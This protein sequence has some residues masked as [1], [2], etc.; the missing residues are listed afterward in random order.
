MSTSYVRDLVTLFIGDLVVF[1]GSLWLALLARHFVAPNSVQYFEHLVPFSI[2]FA[3]WLIVFVIMGLYDR[4]VALF[5]HRLPSTIF[6]AQVVNLLLAI[7]FFFIAPIA[8]QP[9]TILALYFVLSTALIVIWRLGIFRL[10]ST[11]H[12]TECA[13]VAGHGSDIEELIHALRTS[14]H[15]HLTCMA[16]VDTTSLSPDDARARITEMVGAA[17][18]KFLVIDSK[19]LAQIGIGAWPTVT[20]ID[21]GELYEALLSRVALSLIDREAFLVAAHSRGNELYGAVKRGMD[22]VVSFVLGT[23]SLI[24]YPFVWLAVY[25]EDR[26]TLFVTQERVGKN[27]RLFSM[28]KF[29][30]MSG[31]DGGHYGTDG[32]T[33]LKVTRVGNFLRR[34]RIDELPQLWSV[35]LGNQSLVGPRPELPPLVDRYLEEVPQY[36]LRHLVVPG[37]SG[38]AQLYHQAHPHGEKNVD[39]TARKISYDLY[40]VKH[41]SI[42]VD[43]DIALKTI[44]TLAL[45]LGA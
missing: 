38:W 29:R 37:L 22:I 31:S 40:Y 5:E 10:R 12:R 7:A 16:D 20:V 3:L 27:G 26:G 24:V 21:A 25:A 35:F 17:H 2:L 11:A 4:T 30:T 1:A 42:A 19:L 23:L 13:V 44:K 9:K 41:R 8:I 15:T 6:Q 36:D 45:R 34:S 39:E 43:L 18:A 32:K 14:P 28:R 33:K